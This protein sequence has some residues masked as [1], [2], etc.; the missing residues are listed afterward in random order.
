MFIFPPQTA[1]TKLFIKNGAKTQI[2][3][4]RKNISSGS[5]FVPFRQNT[6]QK[7]KQN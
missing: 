2:C 3:Y 5:F 6:K 4:V 7:K 1:L